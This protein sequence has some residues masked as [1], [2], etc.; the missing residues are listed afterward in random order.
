MTRFCLLSSTSSGG[1]VP[2]IFK[3]LFWLAGA[4]LPLAGFVLLLPC[5]QEGRQPAPLRGNQL[6]THM[7]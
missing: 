5:D 2:K 1:T 7:A 3:M 4:F 6:L